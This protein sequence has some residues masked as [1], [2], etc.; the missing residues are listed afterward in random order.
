MPPYTVSLIGW[1]KAS[2]AQDPSQAKTGTLAVWQE[3]RFAGRSTWLRG[4]LKLLEQSEGFE[5]LSTGSDQMKRIA[6]GKDV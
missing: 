5:V 3:P 1:A 2:A 6:K 4:W